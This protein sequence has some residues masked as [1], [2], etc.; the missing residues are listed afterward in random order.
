MYVYKA[1]IAIISIIY[2]LT[3]LYWVSVSFAL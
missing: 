2:Q 3:Y 1:D